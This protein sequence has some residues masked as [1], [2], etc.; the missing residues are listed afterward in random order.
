M[1][2]SAE[3]RKAGPVATAVAGPL[4]AI[5][6][7]SRTGPATI[8]IEILLL[9]GGLGRALARRSVSYQTMR[10]ASANPGR[11]LRYE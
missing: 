5:V 10:A 1:I 6:G 2:P 7:G 8:G 9:A 3:V 11:S 4:R